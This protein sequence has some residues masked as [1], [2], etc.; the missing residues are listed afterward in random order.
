MDNLNHLPWWG[1]LMS[2]GFIILG[3]FFLKLW[4]KN[5]NP[6]ASYWERVFRE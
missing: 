6:D 4:R 2:I 5:I 3:I 1:Y